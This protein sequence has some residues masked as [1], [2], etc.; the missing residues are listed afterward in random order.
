[1]S[2]SSILYIRL[3]EQLRIFHPNI[4][5]KRIANWVWIV[6]GLIQSQSVHLSE[7]AQHIPSHASRR[8]SC[9]SA[10]LARQSFRQRH[11]VL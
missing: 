5:V 1:M 10:P 11:G 9:P 2:S 6:V 7:I 3:F 4:H 8:T